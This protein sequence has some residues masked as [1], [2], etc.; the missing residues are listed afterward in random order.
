MIKL[1]HK[2]DI[3]SR[4][5]VWSIFEKILVS[6]WIFLLVLSDR[7]VTCS[8]IFIFLVTVTPRSFWEFSITQA[9]SGNFITMSRLYRKWCLSWL[10]F[11]SISWNYLDSLTD[12]FFNYFFFLVH[13]GFFIQCKGCY[14]SWR[15]YHIKYIKSPNI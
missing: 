14:R 10:F 3:K 1:R 11:M 6:A 12:A 5:C 15:T 7:L 9:G 2:I 8:L 13:I 4:Y